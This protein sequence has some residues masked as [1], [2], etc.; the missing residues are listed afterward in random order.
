M[1]SLFFALIACFL[2]A[3]GA[4]D[5]RLVAMLSTRLG[6][7]NALLA[8]GWLVS[9]ITAAL[10][11]FAGAGLALLL[12]PAGKTMLVAFALLLAALELAWPFRRREPEEPTR[13]LFAIAVVLGARQ[14]GDGARFLVVAIAAA[15]GAPVLA[16][17][18]GALG[19]GAA[20]TLGWALGENLARRYPVRWIRL[21]IAVALV[22]AAAWSALSARGII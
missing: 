12:P 22:V 2:A 5:Q 10:A 19:G 6:A 18:G 20:L 3:F 1:P 21:G 13:S 7:S 16:A 4:R 11:A 9:A 14:V 8:T 17:I 15:T